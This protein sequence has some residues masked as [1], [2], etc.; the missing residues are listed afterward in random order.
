MKQ[1]QESVMKAAVSALGELMQ[2]A[3][4]PPD[5]AA[6]VAFWTQRMGV[7]PFYRLQHCGQYVDELY[8]LGSPCAADYSMMMAY[9]GDIQIEL[10]EQHNDSPSVYRPAGG[11]IDGLHHTCIVVDDMDIAMQRCESEGGS[12]LQAGR[13]H[14]A[15]FVYYDM[16]GGP[17]TMLEM[18]FPGKINPVAAQNRKMREAARTWDGTRPVRDWTD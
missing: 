9:W 12:L 7:G 1:T 3:F 13:S 2:M 6:A 5:M 8:Y 18:L 15:R 11:L 10:I 16:G 14:D 4:V 17:G